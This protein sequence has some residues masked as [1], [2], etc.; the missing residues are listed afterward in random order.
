MKTRKHREKRTGLN[1]TGMDQIGLDLLDNT[2]QIPEIATH[3]ASGMNLFH[4]PIKR[5]GS[6]KVQSD[7]QFAAGFVPALDNKFR[8]LFQPARKE[9]DDMRRVILTEI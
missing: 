4:L 2:L 1:W 9:T 8:I 7:L 3:H 5:V 6:V